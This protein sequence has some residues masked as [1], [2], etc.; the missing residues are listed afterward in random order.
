MAEI[1]GLTNLQKK[2]KAMPREVKRGIRDAQ[3][4]GAD[5]VTALQKQLVPV[6]TGGLRDSIR[7]YDASDDTGI[8]RR[9]VAGND[10]AYHAAFVEFGTVNAPAHPYFFAAYRALKKRIKSRQTRAINKALRKVA[11]R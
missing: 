3:K 9:M 4:K 5:E 6:Q 2:L 8:R 11:A 7:N 10:E 1:K